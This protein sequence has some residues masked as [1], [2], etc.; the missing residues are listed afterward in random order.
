MSEIKLQT[1]PKTIEDY[2]VVTVDE[3]AALINSGDGWEPHG[4]AVTFDGAIRQPMVKLRSL[5]VEELREEM[6]NYMEAAV[7]VAASAQQMLME[8]LSK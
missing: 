8:T 1:L 6:S 5:T 4:S 2:K 7:A 3:V